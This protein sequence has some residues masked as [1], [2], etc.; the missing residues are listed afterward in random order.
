MDPGSRKSKQNHPQLTIMQYLENRD[1]P[2][3]AR[4][5][6]MGT[7]S[8]GLVGGDGISPYFIHGLSVVVTESGSSE[9]WLLT[10][11]LHHFRAIIIRNGEII[12]MSSEFTPETERQRLQYLVRVE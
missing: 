4:E 12:P 5:L 10:M 6:E 9:I 1:T 8:L 11:H 2:Q 3:M 7:A